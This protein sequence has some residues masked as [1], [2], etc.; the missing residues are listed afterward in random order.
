[1]STLYYVADP[2]CSWCWGFA[3]TLEAI[4]REL[5]PEVTL[6]LVLGGLAP[7]SDAPMDEATKRYVQN[8]WRAVAAQTGARFDFSFW[9]RCQA[10]RSTW[11]ACRAVLAAGERGREMFAAIQR[12]YYT[13]AR[14]PSDRATLIDLGEELGFERDA[15][16]TALDA[17]PTH[18]G[19]QADFALRDELG[20]S[21]FPSLA[22]E[23]NGQKGAILGGWSDPESVRT[24]LRRLE[25]LA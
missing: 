17:P 2:M 3:T 16:E 22:L 6:Q 1:M 21:G 4:E 19:L 18:A 20:V 9:E 15:F 10:R 13:E 14:N 12:A 24:L 7:D 23:R 25:L 5:R 8:A 11:P